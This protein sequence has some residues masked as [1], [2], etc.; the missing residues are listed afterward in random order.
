[1]A[2]SLP[3]PKPFN[4]G[5]SNPA[6]GGGTELLRNALP[7]RGGSDTYC[8]R[9]ATWL[10]YD[11]V[12]LHAPPSNPKGIPSHARRAELAE[13]QPLLSFLTDR[14]GRTGD[15]EVLGCCRFPGQRKTP[16][17]VPSAGGA[18]DISLYCGRSIFNG[19]LR[20]YFATASM[21]AKVC[22]AQNT[23]AWRNQSA[24]LTA[25]YY[26]HLVEPARC[27]SCCC[28]SPRLPYL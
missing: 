24:P 28:P 27:A 4:A 25:A 1:M 6:C 23:K 26:D 14:V 19:R 11:A 15:G 21:P 2:S 9:S 3:P 22:G 7:R 8:G 20:W 12:R 17:G 10:W 5:G 13:L 18:E 16:N